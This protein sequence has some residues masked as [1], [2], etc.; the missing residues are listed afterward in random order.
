VHVAHRRQRHCWE[1]DGKGKGEALQA[2]LLHPNEE[3]AWGDG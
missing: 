3:E 1:E 2:V